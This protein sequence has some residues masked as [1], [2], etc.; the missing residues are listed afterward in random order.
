RLMPAGAVLFSSRA[1]IGYV[2]IAANPVS[3]NQGFKSFVLNGDVDPG[4]LYYYLQRARELALQLASVTTF[5]EISGKS[6]KRIPLPLPPIDEQKQIVEALET[7]FARLDDA[8]A[9]HERART[10][11]KRYRASVL[12]SACGGTLVPTEADLARQEG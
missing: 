9:A 12:K 8:V 1:P 4:Y 5:P 11:F 6:A 7:Q 2:A 3:T 10:R